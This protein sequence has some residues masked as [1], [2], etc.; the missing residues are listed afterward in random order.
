MKTAL[1]LDHDVGRCTRKVLERVKEAGLADELLDAYGERMVGEVWREYGGVDDVDQAADAGLNADAGGSMITPN[2]VRPPAPASTVNH[3][4][5]SSS[6]HNPVAAERSQAPRG[7]RRVDVELLST[8][9]AL[10]ESLFEVAGQWVRL[11]DLDRRQCRLLQ[12]QY[13]AAAGTF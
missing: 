12:R 2:G 4:V 8:R 1:A 13:A 5:A 11:G 9:S 7:A 3:Q 6:T 10:L